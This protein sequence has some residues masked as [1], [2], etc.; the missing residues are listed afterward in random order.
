MTT[1]QT[2]SLA[3]FAVTQLKG[4]RKFFHKLIGTLDDSQLLVRAGGKGNH[5]LWIMGHLALADDVFV[6]AFREEPSCLPEE[7][8][9]LF[10]PG[11]APLDDT[12]AYPN[13]QELL[14]RLA[15]AR[16]RMLAWVKTLEGDAAWQPT[17]E[18]LAKIAPDAISTAY[19]MVKHE[20]IHTGQVTCIRASLG[21]PPL[22]M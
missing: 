7:H 16:V 17:P 21:L 1:L 8:G 4:S 12:A 14:Q 10:A 2:C 11:T 19:T 15:T 13:R 6:S 9:K 18:P 3:E 20:S 5:A 22:F